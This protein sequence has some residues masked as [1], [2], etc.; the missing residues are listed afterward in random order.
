MHSWRFQCLSYQDNR[1]WENFSLVSFLLGSANR[2][3]FRV[4]LRSF[5]IRSDACL[6]SSPPTSP[7]YLRRPVSS[8][9]AILPFP[10]P[11]FWHNL[12]VPAII[13]TYQSRSL[14]QL[15]LPFPVPVP[16]L[17]L[18]PVDFFTLP[19]PSP[20][21]KLRERFHVYFT[22]IFLPFPLAKKV[23]LYGRVRQGAGRPRWISFDEQDHPL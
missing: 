11:S 19:L 16:Q 4:I 15:R 14:S 3:F 13:V 1:T 8:S 22:Y 2:R 10:F 21:T 5:G 12:A 7:V 9:D 6:F 17:R 20:T 23:S 18:L